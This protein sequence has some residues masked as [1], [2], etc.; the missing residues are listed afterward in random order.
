MKPLKEPAKYLIQSIA[1]IELTADYY[2]SMITVDSPYWYHSYWT[3]LDL[4]ER[5]QGLEEG[6]LLRA[7]FD[8]GPECSCAEVN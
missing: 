1:T 2:H 5:I 4:L 8:S 6:S 3:A 7:H